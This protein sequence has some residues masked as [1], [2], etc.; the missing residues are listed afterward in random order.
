MTNK[1]KV[2]SLISLFG[3]SN[4]SITNDFSLNF[5]KQRIAVGDDRIDRKVSPS[6]HSLFMQMSVANNLENNFVDDMCADSSWNGEEDD[7]NTQADVTAAVVIDENDDDAVH[8]S[9]HL[10][11]KDDDDDDDND[12]SSG[13]STTRDLTETEATSSHDDFNEGRS[14]ADLGMKATAEPVDGIS[15][16]LSALKG[17]WSE[18]SL[19]PPSSASVRQMIYGHTTTVNSEG[20]IVVKP[21]PTLLRPNGTDKESFFRQILAQFVNPLSRSNQRALWVDQ[22]MVMTIKGKAV[23]AHHPTASHANNNDKIVAPV[24]VGRGL[25]LTCPSGT[26]SILKTVSKGLAHSLASDLVLL[27]RKV[28]QGV[29]NR[30]MAT[31]VAQRL[32]LPKVLCTPA[33]LLAVLLDQIEARRR[34]CTVVLHDDIHWFAEGDGSG[35][36]PLLMDE[37]YNPTSRT[38]FILAEPDEPISLGT[39]SPSAKS[40]AQQQAKLAEAAAE[41]A[42]AN[43]GGPRGNPFNFNF[44]GFSSPSTPPRGGPKPPRGRPSHSTAKGRKAPPP[45]SPG[46]SPNF[47]FPP[48]PL[49]PVARSFSISVKNG[50]ASV[51]PI[52]NP[53]PHTPG[54]YPPSFVPGMHPHMP[55]PGAIPLPEFNAKQSME[56]MK[57]LLEH[58]V[59]KANRRVDE[60]FMQGVA[61]EEVVASGIFFGEMTQEDMDDFMQNAENQVVMKVKNNQCQSNHAIVVQR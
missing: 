11:G 48:I 33:G 22:E 5:G 29:Q 53:D 12:N 58:Q 8:T 13:D 41:A 46:E 21:D 47:S 23:L 40:K 9:D 52:P 61:P 32:A 60:A 27:N 1:L 49:P 25:K 37:L 59:R 10:D 3:L 6:G 50:S 17:I 35:C 44:P 24:P 18:F 57:R 42:A 19:V 7:P 26:S 15:R 16:A 39:A 54:S 38:L 2:L 28:L 20:N 55:P 30:V 51:S 43:E 4:G 31:A 14:P 56:V 36:G 45:T 34:P